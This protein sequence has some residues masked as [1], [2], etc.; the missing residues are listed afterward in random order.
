MIKHHEEPRSIEERIA[1]EAAEAEVIRAA[2]EA[3]VR[4]PRGARAHART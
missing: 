4:P 2:K 1:A 3:G